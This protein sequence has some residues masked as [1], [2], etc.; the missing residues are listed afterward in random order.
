ML[1]RYFEHIAICAGHVQN[2]SRANLRQLSSRL[3]KP[4]FFRAD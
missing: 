2:S 1:M 3:G 4:R